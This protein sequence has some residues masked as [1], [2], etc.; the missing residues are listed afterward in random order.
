MNEELTVECIKSFKEFSFLGESFG[1]F[2]KGNKYRL[3]LFSAIPFI[4]NNIMK[5]SSN[6]KC[7]NIDVQRFAIDERDD[8]KLIFRDNNYFLNKIKIFRIFVEKD[9]KEKIKP[10]L[11]LDRYNS[12]MANIIDS[13]LSKLLRLAKAQLSLDDERRLT[14]SERILFK[15][16]Y[17]FIKMWRKFY[18]N[19]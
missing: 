3:K 15:H 19:P 1:P 7:D 6:E 10:P 2:E 14:N 16:I 4:E 12:Y 17:N 18:L 9:I 8:Q 5:I 13:R 11:D